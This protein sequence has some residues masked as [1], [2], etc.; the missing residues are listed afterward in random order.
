MQKEF[1]NAQFCTNFYTSINMQHSVTPSLFR[2]ALAFLLFALAGATP[3]KAQIELPPINTDNFVLSKNEDY[4]TNDRVF[5]REDIVFMKIEAPAIDFTGLAISEYTLEPSDGSEGVKGEFENQFDGSYLARFD[6]STTNSPAI[7]WAWHALLEDDKGNQFE[8]EAEFF[9]GDP[10]NDGIEIEIS[11]AMEEI[12]E[13]FFIFYGRKVIVTDQ[14]EIVSESGELLRLADFM[15]GDIASVLVLIT[16]E[17]ADLAFTALHIIKED[18]NRKEEVEV[19]GL[20]TELADR[21]F[22]VQGLVFEINDETKIIGPNE[23]ELGFGDLQESMLVNVIGQYQDDG[24]LTAILVIVEDEDRGEFSITG[25]ILSIEND[26]IIVQGTLFTLTDN[27]IILSAEGDVVGL[28]YLEVGQFVEVRAQL[29]SNGLPVAITIKVEDNANGIIFAEGIIEQIFDAGLVVQGRKFLVNDGTDIVDEN[30][31]PIS[32]SGLAEGLEVAVIGQYISETEMEAILI[33][34][35]N[36]IPD[37]VEIEGAITALKEEG[38]IVQDLFFAVTDAT[39]ILNAEGEQLRYGDLSLGMFVTVIG[40][41]SDEGML[42]ATQI[43]IE[44]RGIVI[45]GQIERIDGEAFYV[46]GFKFLVTDATDIIGVNG[47]EVRFESLHVGAVVIVEAEVVAFTDANEEAYIAHSIILIDDVREKISVT[48]AILEL[49]DERFV[50]GDYVFVV[51]DDTVVKDEAGNLIDYG[52]LQP[53]LVVEIE[54]VVTTEGILV[55]VCIQV[56]VDRPIRISGKIEKI[57]G[58][59]IVVGGVEFIVTDDTE[60][61]SVLGGLLRF[62]DL[63]VGMLA[64]VALVKST[65]DRLI[66]THMQVLPRIEDEV[67]VTGVVEA[68]HDRSVVILGRTFY[69]TENT[70]IV[71]EQDQPMSLSGLSAGRTVTVRADLLPGDGLIALKIKQRDA[72][73]KGIQVTGPVE[74]IESNTVA[75]MGIYFFVDANTDI[76]NLDGESISLDELEIGKTVELTALGQLDGTRLAELILEQDVVV[77]SGTV[78]V[79]SDSEITLLGAKFG[80]D[81]N[82]LVLDSVNDHLLRADLKAGQYVEIRGI[83]TNQA[84]KLNGSSIVTKVKVLNESIESVGIEESDVAT[85]PEGFALHQNYPNPFNPTTTISFAMQQAG[86]VSLTIYTLLG[87]EVMQLAQGEFTPGMHQVQW[88]GRDF[89]GQLVASG[90]YLYR[91]E[92]GSEV[93]TRQMVFLK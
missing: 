47:E 93:Q 79:L 67:T 48:G 15:V 76:F 84:G 27:T 37:E 51:G 69:V 6:L 18:E 7:R 12:G 33:T 40:K 23:E 63:Q 38:L 60:I 9:V 68:I 45:D 53:G 21:V 54:A 72:Q 57:E 65:T 83:T 17:G 46:G 92:V 85:V 56:K 41:R 80:F 75:V 24:T 36:G 82:A 35:G 70:V 31:Q 50:V 86:S 32:F 3:G 61:M 1:Q 28:D 62:E 44:Q 20:I 5:D 90:V 26:A 71:D 87:Q 64:R 89:A 30:G 77:A 66:A 11:G 4:S 2:I 49:G 34:L 25:N 58:E 55:A 73:E 42:Y 43:N 14:T 52:R 74:A 39:V 13:N 88:N 78:T 59:V 8:A 10:G 16:G 29:G 81:A 22:V 91:L 19:T